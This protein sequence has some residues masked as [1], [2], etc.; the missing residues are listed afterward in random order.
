MNSRLQEL[1]QKYFN[2]LNS[3][4]FVED[5]LDYSVLDL[6]R[7]TLEE[8]DRLG[9]SSVSVFDLFRKTHVYVSPNYKN[10]VGLPDDAVEGPEGFDLLM[11]P[12]D[13]VFI[14]EAGY[15]FMKLALSRINP[16]LSKFRLVNDFRIRRPD[17]TWVRMTE[18]HRILETDIHGNLW[19]SLSIADISSEQNIRKPA[20]SRLIHQ[21]TGEIEIFLQENPGS[22]A[23]LSGRELQILKL[24]SSGLISKQIAGEL[25]ISLH[26]VNTH[27]QNIISKMN[28]ANTAEAVL[29]A[30]KL[31]LIN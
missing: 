26:T 18:Q 27:R 15:Y 25:N 14:A 22:I 10:R 31:G 9:K 19:L 30:M 1:H 12:H 28:A 13:R 21:E 6:H 23:E 17:R 5:D 11:H 4:P 24:I 3:I 7:P 16:D 29:T 8:F 20:T 2:L